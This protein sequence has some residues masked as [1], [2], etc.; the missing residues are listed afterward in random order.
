M[1][2]TNYNGS[3]RQPSGKETVEYNVVVNLQN[4]IYSTNIASVLFVL[5]YLRSLFSKNCEKYT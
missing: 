4:F 3:G 1:L 2:L 5:Y